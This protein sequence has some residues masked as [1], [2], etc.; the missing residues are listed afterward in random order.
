PT[1]GFY[2]LGDIAALIEPALGQWEVVDGPEVDQDLT[3]RFRGTKGKILRCGGID[4]DGVFALLERKLFATQK[5]EA[6]SGAKERVIFD[7][8]VGGDI[9]DA[10]AFAVMHALADRG[11]IEILAVGIV[12]GH[13]LAVPYAD[14]VNT[15]Y[16]RPDIPIG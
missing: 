6:R 7:T 11:E 8:D 1:K 14:A 9:D 15:W 16:G 4:R 5:R 2:D 3:Y 12:N 10:G 13:E